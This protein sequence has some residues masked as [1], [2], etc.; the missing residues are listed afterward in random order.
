[1]NPTDFTSYQQYFEAIANAHIALDTAQPF[2]FG[3]ADVVQ[4]EIK[5]WTGK[6]LWLEPHDPA[7]VIDNFS[8]N[9]QAEKKG[10]LFVCG[11]VGSAKFSDEY[12]YFQT[13]EVIVLDILALIRKR[14]IDFQSQFKIQS[15]KY[16][17]AEFMFGSTK[18]VGCRLDFTYMDP[19][20]LTFYPEKW[21]TEV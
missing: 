14:Y 2:V 6:K 9:V 3:D 7:N 12:A 4:N 21:K 11:A 20:G 5:H 19:T 16:G 15:Y 17:H 10:T 1:M 18:L 13:C 8:D